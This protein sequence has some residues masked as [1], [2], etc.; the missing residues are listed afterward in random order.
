M[1][2]PIS[3][4]GSALRLQDWIRDRVQ[5]VKDR[6]EKHDGAVL[7][8]TQDAMLQAVKEATFEGLHKRG[9]VNQS[10]SRAEMIRTFLGIDGDHGLLGKDKDTILTSIRDSVRDSLRSSGYIDHTTPMAEAIQIILGIGRY[11]HQETNFEMTVPVA[12]AVAELCATLIEEYHDAA[13]SVYPKVTLEV[14]E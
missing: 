7:D 10:M 8:G 3:G 9:Y 1:T 13:A 6:T 11:A 14:L 2:D 12:T 4:V 5:P